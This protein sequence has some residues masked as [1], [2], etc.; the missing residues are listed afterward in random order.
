MT[1]RVGVIGV[2][3]MGADHA[4][5]LD[6]RVGGAA[7]TV[8]ADHDAERAAVVAGDLRSARVVDDARAVFAADD[9]DAVVIASHDSTH[10]ELV[11][12]ALDAGKPVLCEK[13]LAPT[14]AECRRVV[15]AE[16]DRGL[17][18][19]GFMRRFDPSYTD[20]RRLVTSGELGTPLTAHCVSRTVA[21]GPGDSAATITNSAIHEL[22][23]LPWLLESPIAEVTWFAGRSSRHSPDRRDPQILVMRTASDVL[24]TVE[25][26][27][28][29]RYG[30]DTRCE[31]VGETG[32]AALTLP[33]R[34]VVDSDRRRG[35][36]YPPDWIPRYADAYRLQLQNWVDAVVT[37]SPSA[38]ATAHDGLRAALVADAAVESMTTGRT[39]VVQYGLDQD[40]RPA[41]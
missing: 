40:G 23:V 5:N 28:N 8:V 30:Y 15:E 3:V 29:A 25:V 35:V 38:L 4:R 13:P 1:L 12:A 20:L 33:A 24:V 7:V 39:V 9:V 16:G 10:Q 14:A 34:V 32:A 11:L 27:L 18:S 19:V 17:V 36:Q 21:S 31:V 26:F 22:D 41:R 2:G 6:R 37:G